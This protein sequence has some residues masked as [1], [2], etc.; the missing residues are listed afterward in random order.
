MTG[1]ERLRLDQLLVQRGFYPTRARARDAIQ[2]GEIA[3]AGSVERK[4][5]AL[6]GP[7]AP[8]VSTDAGS[9]YVSRGALKLIA[10]LDRFG[11]SPAGRACLDLGASTGGFT[12]VLLERGARSV[13][14]VD[15][16]HGQLH[17]SVGADAR[18]RAIEGLNARDL[19]PIHLGER[20]GFVV[21]DLSFISL[22]IALPPA[23]D[24]AAE[25]AVGVFLV[26]PQ[27]EVGRDGVGKGGIVRDPAEAEAAVIA[28]EQFLAE[29]SWTVSGRMESP[30]LGGDGNREYLV[31]ARR[32]G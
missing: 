1:A 28:I 2:R 4:P 27:F 29:R 5:G 20:P 18:V 14:A 9:R 30:I 8:I 16:G 19:T 22:R 3:V 11:L 12:Q 10:A 26:K 24:L 23:L 31:A 21:A 13:A 15:V 25:D 6:V 7:D 32:G 17:P